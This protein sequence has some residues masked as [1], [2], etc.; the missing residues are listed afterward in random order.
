MFKALTK[1]FKFVG[2]D[3][4]A[5]PCYII[6]NNFFFFIVLPLDICAA[7]WVKLEPSR[8][9]QRQKLQ[10]QIFEGAMSASS[11]PGWQRGLLVQ[12]QNFLFPP[13]FIPLTALTRMSEEGM[14]T[15]PLPPPR[16]RQ[17]M[18]RPVEARGPPTY[19][20]LW[21]MFDLPQTMTHPLLVFLQVSVY[22]GEHRKESS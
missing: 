19:F 18:P 14:Y 12:S 7:G 21:S 4:G 5:A 8:P 2:H 6:L 22:A 11:A 1:I 17:A 9:P 15:F 13:L 16:P 3:M 10:M 20:D